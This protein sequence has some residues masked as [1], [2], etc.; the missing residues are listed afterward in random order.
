MQI[1]YAVNQR[2]SAPPEREPTCL[3]GVD[4]AIEKVVEASADSA[5]VALRHL[6]P[7]LARH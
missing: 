2:A 6:V 7:S 3:D 4:P 1:G 5:R